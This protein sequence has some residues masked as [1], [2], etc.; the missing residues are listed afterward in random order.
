MCKRC[1]GVMRE[2]SFSKG[3]TTCL[4]CSETSF[5]VCENLLHKKKDDRDISKK[6]TQ[7][8]FENKFD[9]VHYIQSFHKTIF[10]KYFIYV[11]SLNYNL[12]MG[13]IRVF[14]GL[15]SSTYRG[16]TAVLSRIKLI[17]IIS[18]WDTMS[19]DI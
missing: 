6:I 10:I 11:A 2:A 1:S 18:K 8:N 5:F 16:S 19:Q 13:V 7:T 14:A 9:S 12:G 3:E 4:P 15:S 17:L